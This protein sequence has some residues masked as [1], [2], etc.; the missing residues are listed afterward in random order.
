MPKVYLGLGTNLGNKEDNLR[1]A[2]NKIKEQ[3]GKV[4]SLSAFHHSE[5]WGFSSQNS[6]LNAALCIDTD[7]SPQQ[8]LKE[9]QSIE[10]EIGRK[11]KSIDGNYSDRLIDIDILLYDNLILKTETLVIPHPLMIQRAFVMT[12][13][14]EIAPNFIH[15]E[16]GEK[17][18]TIS[19]K[20]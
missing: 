2:I 11:T 6:F 8:I 1:L 13:L 4:I 10:K 16:T 12:P 3:I 19:N 18:L 17:L 5:P 20:L 14:S 15:P 9:T 7:L